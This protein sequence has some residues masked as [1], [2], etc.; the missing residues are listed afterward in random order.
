MNLENLS[1]VILLILRP[2]KFK[3]K[4]LDAHID[5]TIKER[6]D[7]NER[8]DE[9]DVQRGRK[10]DRESIERLKTKAKPWIYS[11]IDDY[12]HFLVN[13]FFK[14]LVW[15]IGGLTI[16]FVC[17]SLSLPREWPYL[18]IK[19]SGPSVLAFAALSRFNRPVTFVG[20]S[21][22][23]KTSDDLFKS[24]YTIGFVLIIATLAYDAWN[25]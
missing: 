10:M 23:E 20:D 9:L 6:D 16:V 24:L 7:A 17:N 13:S 19:I 12:R 8:R 21:L 18:I 14:V 25:K 2:A 5:K 1:N 22:Q 11:S 3:S 15:V 4:S